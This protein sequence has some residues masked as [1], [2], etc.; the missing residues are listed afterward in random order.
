MLIFNSFIFVCLFRRIGEL[1]K[2]E[3]KRRD[4]HNSDDGSSPPQS[5]SNFHTMISPLLSF[6]LRGCGNSN[7]EEFRTR[8][9]V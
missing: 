5:Y 1:E 2:E 9:E 3:E 6:P 4:L 7:S 8:E